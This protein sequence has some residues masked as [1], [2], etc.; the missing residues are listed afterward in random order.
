MQCDEKIT[1]PTGNRSILVIGNGLSTRYLAHL[2]FDKIPKNVDTFGMGAAHRYYSDI[3]WWPTYYALCDV[4]VVFHNQKE[5]KAIVE[6][7]RIPVRK[8]FLPLRLSDNEKLETVPHSSTGSFCMRKAIEL[9]YKRIFIIGIETDYMEQIKESRVLTPEEI[10]QTGLGQLEEFKELPANSRCILMVTKTPLVNTNYFFDSYQRKG[11]I[12]SLPSGAAHYRQFHEIARLTESSKVNIINLSPTSPLTMFPKA[13]LGDF[14]NAKT[15]HSLPVTKP[16]DTM[17]RNSRK[18]SNGAMKGSFFRRFSDYCARNFPVAVTLGRFGKWGLT[19]LKNTFFGIGGI[20]LMVIVGLY[21]AG[22]LIEP[23]RWYLVGIASGLL[24]LGGG[25]LALSYARL[26]LNRFTRNQG[27][28]VS[29]I[30]KQVSDMRRTLG[31]AETTLAKMNVGN[32]ALFQ[33]FNRRL[34][35]QDLKHF[36]EEWA[37][38][39]GLSLDSRALAYIAHRICLAEDTCVGRLAGNIETMLL[40]ILVARSVKEP[41]LEVLEIGTLFGVGVAMIHENCRGFFNDVHVT[42]IDPLSGYYGGDNLDTMTKIPVTCEI[43]IHN[44]QRMNIPKADYTI[45]EKLSTEDEAI[46]QASKRC[47]NL[48]IIDGDHSYIGTKHDF[49]NYRHL[50]KRGG[51]IVFDDYNNPRWPEVKDFVGKEVVGLPELE[52]VG[53]DFYTAVFKVITTKIR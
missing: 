10:E 47:Y 30:K 38:K 21:V 36:A 24:L 25:L 19:I 50:V 7:P 3:G 35:K 44:M 53:T 17:D 43:F 42:V 22:A 18:V 2:G 28:Q 37:P 52:F 1:T 41:D 23:A 26:W 29:D 12:Y 33:Q 48:L 32:F 49:Y 4:K 46:E 40:R 20:A 6:D 13:S 34:T 39:L 11:D 15:Y 9:G 5:L 14:L 51:Y 31:A 27:R 45:I 8:Y 16:F